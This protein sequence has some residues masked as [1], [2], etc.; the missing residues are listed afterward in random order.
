MLR[1]GDRVARRLDISGARSANMLPALHSLLAGFVRRT[2]LVTVVAMVVCAGFA[3][4]AVAALSEELVVDSLSRRTAPV[5]RVTSQPPPRISLDGA[6]L[7]MRNIFCST[8]VPSN[9][10]GPTGHYQGQPAILI[11]TGLGRDSRATVRVLATD[12]QGDWSVGDTIPGVGRVDRIGPTSIDVSDTFGEHARLSLL[13]TPQPSKGPGA[14]TPGPAKPDD[15]PGVNKVSEGVYEVERSIVRE[16]VTG[17]AKPTG[18]RATPLIDSK[19]GEVKGVRMLGVR[20]GSVAA[21]LGLKSNDILDAINGEPIKTAQQLLDL[22]AKLDMLNNVELSGTRGGKPLS[23][24]L[25]LR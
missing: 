12:V 24:V 5:P 16:L 4:H 19:S 8:C 1:S 15:F 18:V 7:V 20:P 23:L 22:Y 17:A 21:A 9:E 2:W 14:A 6:I 25:R 11:A 13:E 10:P 3:A